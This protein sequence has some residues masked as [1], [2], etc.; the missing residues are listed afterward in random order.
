M[1]G[2]WPQQHL[3]L[4]CWRLSEHNAFDDA[5]HFSSLHVHQQTSS[6]SS[7]WRRMRYRWPPSP[8]PSPLPLPASSSSSHTA[9]A[10]GGPGRAPRR[11]PSP[12]CWPGAP[13]VRCVCVP[14]SRWMTLRII[15]Y[16]LFKTEKWRY[17][18]GGVKGDFEKEKKIQKITV[19]F[20][21]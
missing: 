11:P 12:C 13:R 10:T 9:R 17:T 15:F 19:W 14:S 16:F 2:S 1:Y 3:Y 20:L 21:K 6:R 4:W 8:S 5:S 7:S 18:C